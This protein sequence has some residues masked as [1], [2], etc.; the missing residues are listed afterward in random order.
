[1]ALLTVG[2]AVN[3]VISDKTISPMTATD[4]SITDCMAAISERYFSTG[5]TLVFSWHK[6][7]NLTHPGNDETWEDV[8]T[9]L[10]RRLHLTCQWP[11]TVS[12][13]NG[14]ERHQHLE[15]GDK[16]GSYVLIVRF[17]EDED[18]VMKDVREQTD[19]LQ[20]LS[21]WD[22]RARFVVV[23]TG[24]TTEDNQQGIIKAM[25]RE[26]S[27]IQVLN[28]IILLQLSKDFPN[29]HSSHLSDLHV[30][31]WFP[32]SPPS[33]HCGMLKSA[34]EIDTWIS[35]NKQ[36]VL[37]NDLFESKIP[38]NLGFCPLRISA[39]HFPPFIIFPDASNPTLS[40]MGG[41]DM[42]MLKH[43]QE[44]TNV[45]IVLPPR[46][47]NGTDSKQ[48]DGKWN[49]PIGDILYNRSDLAL[50]GWC[51][52][53]EDSMVVEGTDS[54]FTEEFTFFIPRVG[55]Y[56][57]Y[58]SMHRVFAPDVWLLIFVLMFLAAV[59]FYLVAVSQTAGECETYKSITNCLLSAWSVVLGVGVHKMPLSQPLRL[60]FFLWL[61]YSLAINTIFQTYVTTY[62]VDPGYRHQID[63]AEEVIES[64]LEVHVIDFLY[65]FLGE[66]LLRNL[67]SWRKCGNANDCLITAFA[68]PDVVMVSG[69]VFVEYKS[70]EQ[71]CKF[72]YHESTSDLFHFHTVM[73][74]K[75]G[76]PY[77]DRINTVIRRLVEGGY[78]GKF[79][80]DITHEKRSRCLSELGQYV[81]MSLNHLQSAFVVMLTGLSLSVLLFFG[82][83]MVKLSR[84]NTRTGRKIE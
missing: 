34:I 16:H 70:A 58:L 68:A 80:K 55:M 59:M 47:D 12:Y 31:T 4:Q 84:Q 27:D 6:P 21:S 78:P 73:V 38:S 40:E 67:K 48:V 32:F 10:L 42:A 53:F 29:R 17:H 7:A 71:N 43:I 9:K 1:M 22:P 75:K 83:L 52:T 46:A 39:F 8:E 81:S 5:R 28:A 54:Y 11:I 66:N 45:S 44:V 41:V 2:S 37:R 18:R 51:Y 3:F 33:G 77:L 19:K 50:G 26:L 79:F 64:G 72:M 82:E 74:L 61:T 36:F 69:K 63:S 25:L 14:E 35:D 23:M 30:F 15:C 20:L 56:P 76:S 49:G 24:Q 62:I 65:E 60:L 57:R 13:A